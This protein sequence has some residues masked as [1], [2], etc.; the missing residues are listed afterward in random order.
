MLDLIKIKIDSLVTWLIFEGWVGQRQNFNLVQ[1]K[2]QLQ[3]W[4]V[5]QYIVFSL[6]YTYTY[7]PEAMVSLISSEL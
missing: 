6:V 2:V 1:S 7:I 5:L 3:Y 4:F